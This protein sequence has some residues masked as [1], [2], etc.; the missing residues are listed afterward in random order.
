M[1]WERKL[2]SVV[3]R[4]IITMVTLTIRQIVMTQISL[5]FRVVPQITRPVLN[6]VLVRPLMLFVMNLF[7]SIIL[8]MVN[9]VKVCLIVLTR[10]I[11]RWRPRR[12]H[13]WCGRFRL[14]MRLPSLL[15]VWRRTRPLLLRPIQRWV[16]FQMVPVVITFM[17][18]VKMLILLVVRI[19]RLRVQLRV[20][21]RSAWHVKIR[22]LFMMTRNRLVIVHSIGRGL[23]KM[24]IP[25]VLRRSSRFSYITFWSRDLAGRN[26][27]VVGSDQSAR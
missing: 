16:K 12:F 2:S 10:F 14:T 15:S 25:V 7:R 17:V 26:F 9:R 5:C 23:S 6:L 19:R 22:R 3:R 21:V 8:I 27:L 20:V 11:I 4:V 18:S 13:W 24:F 1:L